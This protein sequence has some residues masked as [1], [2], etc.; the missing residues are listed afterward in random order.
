MM[1]QLTRPVRRRPTGTRVHTIC[2]IT[3]S[4]TGVA[5]GTCC[6]GRAVAAGCS[7]GPCAGGGAVKTEGTGPKGSEAGLEPAVGE[8]VVVGAAYATENVMESLVC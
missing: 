5:T 1:I 6:G 7:D 3:A 2:G 4:G 8:G